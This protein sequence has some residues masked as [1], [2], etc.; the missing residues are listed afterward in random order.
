M[1]NLDFQEQLP[2]AKF[3]FDDDDRRGMALDSIVS[4]RLYYFGA[5]V[6][7]SVLFNEVRVCSYSL[8]EDSVV[9]PDVVVLRHCK[10]KNAILDRGCIIPEGMVIGYNHDHDRAKGF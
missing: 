10:I 7:R 1:A 2:P 3:V 5:T 9:L 4:G 6:R 8:V